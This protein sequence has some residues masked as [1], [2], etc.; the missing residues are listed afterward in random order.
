M[1]RG[2]VSPLRAL[3][4]SAPADAGV[5]TSTQVGGSPH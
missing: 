1:N 2:L 4:G 5:R 3:A